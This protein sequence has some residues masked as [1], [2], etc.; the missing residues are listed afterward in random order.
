[1]VIFSTQ[2]T[3]PNNI[4]HKLSMYV[5]LMMDAIIMIKTYT[6]VGG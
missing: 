4:L 3:L 1:M 6:L 2:F 5:S